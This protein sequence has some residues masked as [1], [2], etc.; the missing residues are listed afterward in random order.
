M[1]LL[2]TSWATPGMLGFLYF[3]L[4]GELRHLFY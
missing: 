4:G 3:A 1:R 2:A